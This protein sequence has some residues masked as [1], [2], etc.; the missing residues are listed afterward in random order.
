MVF[1]MYGKFH[2]QW[3]TNK[4]IKND[5]VKRLIQMVERTHDKK[6]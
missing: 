1:A 3:I 6:L 4:A 2:V 5:S